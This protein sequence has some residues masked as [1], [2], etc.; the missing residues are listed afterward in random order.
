MESYKRRRQQ[1]FMH[2]LKS[3]SSK[4]DACRRIGCVILLTALITPQNEAIRVFSFV[5]NNHGV[6]SSYI[7]LHPLEF[8]FISITIKEFPL[9]EFW[10]EEFYAKRNDAPT[11]I[12]GK[13]KDIS[14]WNHLLSQ[15]KTMQAK[16][17]RNERGPR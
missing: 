5:I 2:F 17:L 9:D 16:N 14:L 8:S 1:V 6:S 11:I 7:F 3:I 10:K 13:I 15:N 4:E 12:S